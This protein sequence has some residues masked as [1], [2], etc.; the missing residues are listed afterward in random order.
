MENHLE[1][2]PEGEAVLGAPRRE[3]RIHGVE[4]AVRSGELLEGSSVDER[5]L[6]FIE[7]PY[8]AQLSRSGRGIAASRSPHCLHVARMV[9]IRRHHKPMATQSQQVV[10]PHHPQNPLVVHQHSSPA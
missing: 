1:R 5:A 8:G 10:F 9:R 2:L 4:G 3:R 6:D 7:S